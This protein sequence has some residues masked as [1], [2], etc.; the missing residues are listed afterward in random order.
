MGSVLILIPFCGSR[1]FRII[2]GLHLFGVM[3]LFVLVLVLVLVLLRIFEIVRLLF[4][5]D[6]KPVDLR[7][8]RCKSVQ[9]LSQHTISSVPSGFYPH[10]VA[11]RYCS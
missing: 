7:V 3:A 11:S 2:F 1:S 10:Y 8:N 6:R 4:L 5:S 9:A